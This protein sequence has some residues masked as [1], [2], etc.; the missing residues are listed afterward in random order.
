MSA[1]GHAASDGAGPVPGTGTLVLD[2][3]FENLEHFRDFVRKICRDQGSGGPNH[4]RMEEIVLAV[5]E[6]VVNIIRHALVD[7]PGGPVSLSLRVAGTTLVATLE[8]DGRPF[9]RAGVAEPSFDGSR[10]NGFGIFIIEQLAD[11]VTYRRRPE[12][13][14]RW[15]LVFNWKFGGGRRASN[16]CSREEG[17]EIDP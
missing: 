13:G 1:N 17:D 10:E 4:D 12:G 3:V 14:N 11:Q 15:E 8:D 2:G 6:A 5:N 9:E 7:R 16:G